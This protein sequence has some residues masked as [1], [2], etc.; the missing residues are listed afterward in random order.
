MEKLHNLVRTLTRTVESVKVD[1]VTV[2]GTPN[3]GGDLAPKVI[4]ASE[5]LKAALG[6]DILGAVQDRMA[7]AAPAPAARRPAPQRTT[8]S[9]TGAAPKAPPKAPARKA[10][11]SST[12]RPPRPT[13]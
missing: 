9:S 5:Q 7:P 10:P 12:S 2:L 1:K 13:R 3:G 4:N 6:V 11:A 8:A